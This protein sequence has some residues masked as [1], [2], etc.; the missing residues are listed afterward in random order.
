MNGR[1]H[2]HGLYTPTTP[3][4]M[5]VTDPKEVENM[6]QTAREAL[7]HSR[8]RNVATLDNLMVPLQRY[9]DQGDLA[10]QLAL[11]TEECMKLHI[12]L[13]HRPDENNTLQAALNVYKEKEA[14][15]A[16]SG[17]PPPPGF[18][19]VT[20]PTTGQRK[21]VMAL[22]Q[23]M[24][25]PLAAPIAGKSVVTARPQHPI[26]CGPDWNSLTEQEDAASQAAQDFVESEALRLEA[27]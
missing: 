9:V 24:N 2:R 5:G 7:D 12:A 15:A 13:K 4:H 8:R 17:V 14:M 27:L 19:S 21:L 22:V 6:M 23:S 11:K 10:C 25:I 16:A 3:D 1:C 26:P 18:T 20:L